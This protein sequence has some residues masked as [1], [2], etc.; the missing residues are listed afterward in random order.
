MLIEMREWLS[1]YARSIGYDTSNY[2]FGECFK[3][4]T[5]KLNE[6]E[7]EV[8]ESES[9]REIRLKQKTQAKYMNGKGSCIM[10]IPI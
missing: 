9:E 1:E 3:A 7:C 6:I 10:M 8:N 2:G 4:Y 5:F